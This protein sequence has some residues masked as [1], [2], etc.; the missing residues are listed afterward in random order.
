MSTLITIIALF[1]AG[2]NLINPLNWFNTLDT[3]R[4]YAVVDDDGVCQDPYSPSV[5]TV[6]SYYFTF[7]FDN[8][9]DAYKVHGLWP[10]S[11]S[12]CST[13][14]YPSCCNSSIHYEYPSD[15]DNFIIRN[16]FNTTTTEECFGKHD[17][18]LFEHEY[19][20]HGS[21]MGV[22]NTEDYLDIVIGLYDR[23]YDQYV[24]G[25]CDESDQLWLYLDGDRQ[26]MARLCK[27]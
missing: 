27:R 7:I 10:E 21:C 15:P 11:C 22:N 6:D 1:Q 17:V 25:Q 3:S 14:G 5:C 13:C 26:Y 24:N 18:I 9:T 16:W 19:F 20:K 2:W 12:E 8:K 4:R 23:Y